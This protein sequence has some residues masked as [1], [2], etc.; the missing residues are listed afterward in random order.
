[1]TLDAGLAAR[2]MDAVDAGFDEQVAFTQALVRFPSTRGAE[3][4]IQ[5]FVHRALRDR[6][7]AMDRFTM[8]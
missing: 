6:F 2:V 8:D 5:D 4:P 7:Y 1:M 3:A